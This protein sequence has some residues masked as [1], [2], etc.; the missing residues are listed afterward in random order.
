MNSPIEYYGGKTYMTDII[1]N[2]FPNSYN[3]YVEGFGGGAS[4]LLNKPVTPLEIY[5][6]LY[7]NVY[8]IFKIISNKEELCKLKERLY[9]TP[10]SREIR[11]EYKE[12]LKDTTISI[13]D[14]AYYYFYVNRT[15]FNGV[16]GFSFNPLI[17]RGCSKSIS[18]YLSAIDGLDEIYSR[19]QHC[20]IENLD[21]FYLIDKFDEIDT[22]FYLDPPYVQST[23]KSNQKYGEEFED[24]LHIKLVDRLLNIKGKVL[25]SGY[26]T[27]LYDRLVENGWH[28]YEFDSVNAM[29]DATEVLW[30]NYDIKRNM[31]VSLF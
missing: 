22:F 11:N 16:G 21:I 25:L 29:S 6:D 3:L 10:Y 23:R 9:L 4:V 28:K 20:V 17:R 30:Y 26:D 19:I 15:S 2:H 13:Q 5:N 7:K 27:P 18:G 1:I 12:K 8:S 31:E 24:E 14:R